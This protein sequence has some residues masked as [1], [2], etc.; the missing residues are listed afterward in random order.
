MTAKMKMKIVLLHLNIIMIIYK[1][2]KCFYRVD[3]Y[4][5]VIIKV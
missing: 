5:R 4:K 2:L 1:I 3:N